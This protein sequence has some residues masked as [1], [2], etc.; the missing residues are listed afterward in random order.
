MARS[1]A[2]ILGNLSLSAESGSVLRMPA[3]TSSPWAFTRKS[4]YSP[5]APV[6]GSRV[7]PTPGARL[8]VAVAEHHGLDVHRR[9]EI[10]GD[11]LVVAIGDGAGA[12]PRAEHR[13]DGPAQL[14]VGVL[15]EVGAGVV[16]DDLL[17]GEDQGVEL[18]RPGRRRRR[19][20]PSAPWPRRA[21]CRRARRG[22]RARCARTSPRTAGTSRRRS[23]RRRSAWRGP[24]PTR[25]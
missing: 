7:K 10:V 11:A 21:A 12:V 3:T 9:A 18:A 2:W 22:C 1:S 24:P 20:R 19:R 23:A 4:P 25:R 6:A 17:V 16:A 13:L 5:F 8:V 15:G 14:G